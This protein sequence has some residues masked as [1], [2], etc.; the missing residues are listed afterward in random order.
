MVK[1]FP[2]IHDI[3]F[4]PVLWA[5]GAGPALRPLTTIDLR[6]ACIFPDFGGHTMLTSYRKRVC[7]PMQI[8]SQ[9]HE[10]VL[11]MV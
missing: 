2:V 3:S 11:H 8:S 10:M 5:G 7:L 6:L 1:Y 9:T 4:I